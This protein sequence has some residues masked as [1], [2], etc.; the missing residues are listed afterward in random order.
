MAQ[1][2]VPGHC[3]VKPG[4]KIQYPNCPLGQVWRSGHYRTKPSVESTHKFMNRFTRKLKHRLARHPTRCGPFQT[5]PEFEDCMRGVK[6][7]LQSFLLKNPSRSQIRNYI[8]YLVE[9]VFTC[10]GRR[11]ERQCY[12]QPTTIARKH[13]ETY[14][15]PVWD[16]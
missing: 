4:L 12:F 1:V 9:R 8:D 16:Y 5:L 10:T 7:S 3:I 15:Q 11:L 14:L 6:R 2:F 13:I